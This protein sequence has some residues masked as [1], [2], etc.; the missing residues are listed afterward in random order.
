MK[1]KLLILPVLLALAAGATGCGGE[2]GPVREVSVIMGPGMIFN[3]AD[4]TGTAGEQ[5][6]IKVTNEDDTLE[7]DMVVAGK[8]VRLQP[9]KS[10]SLTV[11]LKKA[12]TLDIKCTLPGHTEAGMV[13]T[14]KVAPK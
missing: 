9:G 3:P 13:G 12:G 11:P 4:L 6:L 10:G 1:R 8:R 2:S 14:I 5:L 7:H